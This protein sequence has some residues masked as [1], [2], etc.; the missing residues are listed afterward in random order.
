MEVKYLLYF[1]RR[2]VLEHSA[3]IDFWRSKASVFDPP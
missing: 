3:N 2:E 1:A